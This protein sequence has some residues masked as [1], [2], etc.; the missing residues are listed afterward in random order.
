MEQWG[1]K[2]NIP[3]DGFSFRGKHISEFGSVYVASA[4]DLGRIGSSIKIEEET[5]DGMDGGY[6]FDVTVEPYVRKFNCVYEDVP[7]STLYDIL[8]WFDRRQEGALIFD[9]RPYAVY[10]ARPTAEIVFSDYPRQG[11]CAKRELHSGTFSIELTAYEPF[12]TVSVPYIPTNETADVDP[13]A[14]ATVSDELMV[15][16]EAQMP[17]A[18]TAASTEFLMYNCGTEYAHTVL[19]AAGEGDV[20]LTNLTTGQ[21]CVVK[22]LTSAATTQLNKYVEL[23]SKTGRTL[24]VGAADTVLDYSYHD[25]GY[26]VISPCA[27]YKRSMNIRSAASSTTITSD[28]GEFEDWMIGMYVYIGGAW[29]EIKDV[30]TPETARIDTTMQSAQTVDTPVVVMNRIQVTLSSGGSLSKLEMTCTPR[31]R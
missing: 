26:I 17:P 28:G 30:M 6:W 20:T 19:R 27:Q 31:V 18:P 3:N 10:T 24:L 4:E 13:V 12:A 23:D 29:H 2:W 1:E 8:R 7:K 25:Y 21:V 22:G 5:P 16:Q 9:D 14:L 11:A 15:L